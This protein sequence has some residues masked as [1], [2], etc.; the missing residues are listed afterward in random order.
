MHNPIPYHVVNM[1]IRSRQS[2]VS[3][4]RGFTLIEA[5][6]LLFIFAVITVTFY[7]VFTLGTTQ[8]I[9]SKNRL[10]A[11]AVAN[12]KMEIIRNLEYDAVGTKKLN[13]DG[14]Y[15]SGIPAGDVLEDESVAVNTK[16][17]TVHSFVQYVDDAFDGKASGTELVDTIPND[18][19]RVKVE[20][21][22]G[23]G[24]A[25]RTVSLVT[26]AAPKGMEV[27]S[28]G[29][30][31]SIN[32]IDNSG[33]GISQANVHI[34]NT[35]V[36]PHIDITTSTDTTGNLMLPGAKA[37]GEAYKIEV[38]KNGYYGMTT[39]A[40]Y[41]TTV[42]KP[43][44]IHASVV[45]ADFN[46]KTIV[47]DKSSDISIATKDAFGA[48]LLN[49]GFHLAGGVK[50]GDTVG[51]SVPVYT[52]NQDDTSGTDGKKTYAQQSSGLYTLTLSDTAKYQLLG[53]SA[54]DAM[55]NVFSLTNGDAKDIVATIIDNDIPAAL[56]LVDD[57]SSGTS[58]PLP[59]ASVHLY[60][61]DIPYDITVVTDQ[62][63]QAYFPVASPALPAGTYAYT[64]TLAGYADKTGT[65]VVTNALQTE[66]VTLIKM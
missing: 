30:T 42:F 27:S 36:S 16:T 40:P 4:N 28:G 37:S 48:D 41:P 62:Y 12:E 51:S 49:I 60:N 32:V 56:V 34:T 59:N 31:L 29:G 57:T 58:V 39:Y 45:E 11:I 47:M 17:F 1:L 3:W 20:V 50:I 19:K 33:S 25:A 63:G 43:I 52:M 8:I 9:E 14:S 7:S 26:T 15:S 23:D 35:S 13:A 38:S 44:Y 53:L 46:Q 21:S 61:A 18:Y 65:I 2:S 5:L 54:P 22:W 24:S 66:N 55:K 6:A 64:V 10:G